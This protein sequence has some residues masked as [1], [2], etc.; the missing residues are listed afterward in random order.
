MKKEELNKGIE[1]Q[2][3]KEKPKRRPILS[4]V[5]ILFLF[6]GLIYIYARY[7]GTMGIQVREY[8][9]INEKLPSSF[10]GFSIVQFSDLELGSTFLVQDMEKLVEKVNELKPDVVVFTGDIVSTQHTL[11][12][13][14]K[15]LL[16]EHLSKMDPL[17]GKY[18]VKGDD[19]QYNG[20]YEEVMDA[21][22][23]K[24]ISNNY[25]LIYYKGLTPIVLYGLDSLNAEAQNF[26]ST[27]SYPKEDEDTTY[28]A[29]FRLL[30]AH[31]PDTVSKI[32][33]YNISL[34]L[35]GHSH[36]SEIN[37]PFLRDYYN[38]RGAS[39]Y[40]SENY[41]VGGTELYISSGLGTSK[42]NVRL[43]SHPS[44]SV[45]RLYTK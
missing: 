13:E 27:F 12:D 38:I 11:S 20:V 22:N 37:I 28:M 42:Y 7:V 1:E 16:I 39:E 6:F 34:M 40:Y 35:S 5:I 45:F 19:D 36:N 3:K 14:E 41:N 21:S 9:I 15:E 23:F 32:G 18:S 24:D 43:M 33:D 44:I 25:E 29:S 8:N 10:D 17:I 31:E 30:L 2:E 26:E 4:K